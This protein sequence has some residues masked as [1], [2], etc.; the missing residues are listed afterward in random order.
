MLSFFFFPYAWCLS[1]FLLLQVFSFCFTV[2]ASLSPFHFSILALSLPLSATF[3]ILAYDFHRHNYDRVLLLHR[4]LWSVAVCRGWVI[5]PLDLTYYW[6]IPFAIVPAL[7]GTILIFLD[8]QITSVI[9]NRKEHKLK[10]SLLLQTN[11][12]LTLTFTS[13]RNR[14]CVTMAKSLNW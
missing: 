6:L 1:S 14:F 9:V 2:L 3:P 5:N 11:L 13:W 8:Q 7:L 12:T 4:V 10:V